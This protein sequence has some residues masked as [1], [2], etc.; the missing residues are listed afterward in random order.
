MGI[1]LFITSISRV[2]CVTKSARVGD[3]VCSIDGRQGRLVTICGEGFSNVSTSKGF[4]LAKSHFPV[5]IE[6]PAQLSPY[7]IVTLR[8]DVATL[9]Y[10]AVRSKSRI[11]NQNG[12][13]FG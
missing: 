10:F 6:T 4:E 9:M 8:V 12:R 1:Q 5:H 3:S 11:W 2:G 13:S 7:R